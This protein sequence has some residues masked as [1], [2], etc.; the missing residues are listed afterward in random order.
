MKVA[1]IGCGF[2]AINQLH[3]WQDAT[4]AELVAVCDRDP[5]RLRLVQEQ[6][7]VTRTYTDARAMFADGGIDTVDIATTVQSHRALVELAARHDVHVICQK[8]F[9]QTMQDARAMVAAVEATGKTL[10]VHENFR[11]Q[12]AV[13][14]AI[15]A[16][17]AG[18][19]GEPFFGRVS[20]RS[21]YD[22]FTGQPYLA[23]GERFIIEDLGIHI[24]DIARALFGD[25]RRLTATTRR[26]NA[27]IEG[28]DV[29]TMLLEHKDGVTCVVDCSYATRREPETFPESLLEIDGTGGTLRLDAGYR[30]TI[31]T[32]DGSETRDVSPPVLPWAERPWHNIQESVALIQQHFV[33]SVAAGTQPETSGAD[34]VLTLALVEAAYLSAAEQRTVEL[35][36]I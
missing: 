15:D 9:A 33:D 3:G 7:G 18:A 25:V 20:F 29:A 14:A 5:E 2:F 26:I 4:G 22:V 11:W 13:R 36:E 17:R 31:Q 28:E 12:S 1:L 6:F 19:I 10:M 24:L 8:P 21:G 32:P 27:K 34:N 35:S 30:L 23:A 16:L